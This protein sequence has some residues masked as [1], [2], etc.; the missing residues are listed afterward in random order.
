MK[1]HLIITDETPG[2]VAFKKIKENLDKINKSVD[3]R[4]VSFN[5][6]TV[7]A[8]SNSQAKEVTSAVYEST[9]VEVTV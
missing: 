6:D 8:E 2:E 3:L 1:W 7:I 9:G 4:L 5:T